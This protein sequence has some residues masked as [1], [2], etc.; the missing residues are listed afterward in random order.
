MQH[1]K[2]CGMSLSFPAAFLGAA[3]WLLAGL[4]ALAQSPAGTVTEAR[5]LAAEARQAAARG[6]PLVVLYSRD[7]CSWCAKLR[8]EHLG[9]LSRNPATPAVIR[10][11]HMDRATPLVD[12]AGRRTTSADF[13]KQMQ[14]RFAPTVMFHGPDGAQLAESIVGYRLADFYGAY[15]DR[16]IEESQAQLQQRKPQ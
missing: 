12:F 1:G 15:L 6:V 8:R 4:P 10:E 5:D 3:F 9:P 13:S 7:D 2:A 11:L 14:A 16:A